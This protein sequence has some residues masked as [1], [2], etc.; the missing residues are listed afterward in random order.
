[1]IEQTYLLLSIPEARIYGT[2]SVQSSE[3]LSCSTLYF[4]S[5]VIPPG[6]IGQYNDTGIGLSLRYGDGSY[7]VDGT[8]GVAPFEFG[9]YTIEKQGLLVHPVLRIL[10]NI[11]LTTSIPKCKHSTL[12]HRLRA[13]T[14]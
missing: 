8:I 5:R 1:M 7:G 6:G 4:T 10:S 3:I 14:L 11:D 13:L 2:G 9:P 12:S